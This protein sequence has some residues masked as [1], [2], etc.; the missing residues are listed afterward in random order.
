MM[1]CKRSLILMGERDWLTQS[2]TLTG[3]VDVFPVYQKIHGFKKI[4]FKLSYKFNI[5]NK[6]RWYNPEWSK[7]L[8]SY[9]KI[10]LFDVFDDDDIAKYIRAKAPNSRLIIYYYNIIKR[11]ELLRKIKKI[12]CEI[13]SFDRNDC[14]KY[15]LFYN[16]QFYFHKLGFLND[17]LRD[18]DYKS[19]IFFVGKDKKR[20]TQLKRLD[21]QFRN[22]GIRTKFIVVGDRKERYTSEQKD[23]LSNSISYAECVEYVKNTKCVLDIV[24]KGQKGM[25]LRIVEAMFFNKKLITNN[26]DILYMDFYNSQNIYVLGHDTRSIKNFIFNKPAQWPKKIIRKYSFENWLANF[27]NKEG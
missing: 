8:S 7:R 22:E 20:L 2:M 14:G 17:N 15:N 3:E 26:D 9:G 21:V 11:V 10:I 16:P 13:W 12:D 1:T 6:S 27:D 19:D 24:Q 25:T 23:Y 18:F 4:L 5:G